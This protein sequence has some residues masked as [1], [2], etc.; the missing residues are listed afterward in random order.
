MNKRIE[1]IKNIQKLCFDQINF[2]KEIH[3]EF[4]KKAIEKL[5][6]KF[7]SMD[8]EIKNSIERINK[9]WYVKDTRLRKQKTIYGAI[10]FPRKTY[11]NKHTKEYKYL[12]DDQINIKKYKRLIPSLE[13]EILNR[14][15]NGNRYCDII[16]SLRD[17]DISEQTISNVVKRFNISDEA[18][19]DLECNKID[20]LDKPYIYLET[21]DTFPI[22]KFDKKKQEY[23]VRLLTVHTG[24]RKGLHKRNYLENKRVDYLL[25][26]NGETIK[27]NKYAQRISRLLNKWFS[28]VE[29][30]RLILLGDAAQWIPNLATE[31][32]AKYVLDKFHLLKLLKAIFPIRGRKN[33]I[34]DKY[35]YFFIVW[36]NK[37]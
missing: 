6:S 11:Q 9:G 19:L 33:D 1:L 27:T 37:Y 8:L 32:N 21:D 7:I 13:V 35:R 31:M 12:V 10:C 15:G 16:D 25:V 20:V 34:V 3:E 26:K 5:I 2:F 14:V 22:F 23:R 36:E 24:S 30:K 29:G 17:A 18:L 28:N 4:L